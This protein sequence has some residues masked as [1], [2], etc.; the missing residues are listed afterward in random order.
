MRRVPQP[1]RQTD[2]RSGVRPV[3]AAHWGSLAAIC[4]PT[5]EIGQC[6]ESGAVG[7]AR[8]RQSVCGCSLF[9]RRAEVFG[10]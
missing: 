4:G 9:G 10:E 8:R 7:Q 1:A 2:R 6:R 3:S 5:T